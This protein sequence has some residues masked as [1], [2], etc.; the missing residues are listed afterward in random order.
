MTAIEE[1]KFEA[2]TL[3]AATF[4]LSGLPKEYYTLVDGSKSIIWVQPIFQ[5]LGLKSLLAASLPVENFT[6]AVIYGK[7][8]TAVVIKQQGNYLAL[9]I[10]PNVELPDDPFLLW[11]YS[12]DAASLKNNPKFQVI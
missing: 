10:E 5:A 6:H 9:L 12:F 8:Y 4:D 7:E 3:G 1:T 2:Y 11:A